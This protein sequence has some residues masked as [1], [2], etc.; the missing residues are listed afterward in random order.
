MLTQLCI[1]WQVLLDVGNIF[2]AIE[3]DLEK[4]YGEEDGNA[5]DEPERDDD[6]ND[7]VKDQHDEL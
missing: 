6:D 1:V 5:E 7:D 4:I 2:Q 3:D